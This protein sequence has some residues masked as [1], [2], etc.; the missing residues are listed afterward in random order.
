MIL[1]SF[2]SK[3][4]GK[5]V[6]PFFVG[7]G[8][9]SDGLFCGKHSKFHVPSLIVLIFYRHRKRSAEVREEKCAGVQEIFRIFRN[10][11]LWHIHSWFNGLEEGKHG[12]I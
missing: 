12:S 3:K 1:D 7:S 2:S 11:A 10:S 4:A 6:S 9:V 5:N 8:A